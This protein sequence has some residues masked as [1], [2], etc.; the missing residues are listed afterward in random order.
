MWKQYYGNGPV[1]NGW[2]AEW[3]HCYFQG[4]KITP[5]KGVSKKGSK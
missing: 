3:L 4:V 1:E 5:E 2:N